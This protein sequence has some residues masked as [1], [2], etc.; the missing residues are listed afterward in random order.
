ML[1]RLALP[2]DVLI[3]SLSGGWKKRVALAQ[4]LAAEPD[5]LLLDEPTNH[6]DLGAIEW[7][8]DAAAGFA[9]AVVC[10]THDRRFLDAVATRIVELDRGRLAQLPGQLR[11]LPGAQGKRARRRGR[12]Q[13]KFDKVLA[14]EEVWIRKGIE[15]RRTRNEGRVRRLEQLRRERAAR[16]ERAR[17]ASTWSSTRASARGSWSP[18]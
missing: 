18:S 8:E 16:R 11:R 10:V 2:A 17:A 6:L 12:R 1:S 14:Q 13:R 7:L 4:A 9:G 3:G 15:A 5:V